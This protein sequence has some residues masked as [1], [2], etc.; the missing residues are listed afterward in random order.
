MGNVLSARSRLIRAKRI[1]INLKINGLAYLVEVIGGIL[2]CTLAFSSGWRL[3][4]PFSLWYGLVVPSC[5]LINADDTKN[6]I[7][8][9]GWLTALR[10]VYTE[11]Q[12]Q[13]ILPTQ[14]QNCHKLNVSKQENI[15]ADELTPKTHEKAITNK[16]NQNYHCISLMNVETSNSD[17]GS[18]ESSHVA[19]F[20]IS[21]QTKKC[22]KSNQCRPVSPLFH[23]RQKNDLQKDK[24]FVRTDVITVI[25]I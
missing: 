25:D 14:H 3:F 6:L 8:E 15:N 22:P 23:R 11:K 19:V 5:Y 10:R 21:G 7:M 13:T 20:H 24:I 1:S 17:V 16:M 18:N 9:H 12:P 4:F 2:I